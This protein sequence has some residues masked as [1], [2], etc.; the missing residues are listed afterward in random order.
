VEGTLFQFT[1]LLGV[2][3]LAAVLSIALRLPVVPLYIIAGVILRGFVQHDHTVEFLGSLG[4]V[5]L[6]FSMGLEFSVAR[7][8]ATP[9][10]ILRAGGLDWLLNFPI[11]LAAGRALGWSWEESLF[12]GGIVYMTSSAVV[13]KCIVD[14]GRAARPETETILG[15]L[16]FEDFVI[17]FYLVLLNALFPSAAAAGEPLHPALALARSL[18]FVLALAVVARRLQGPL[19]RM[20]AARTEEA[21]TLVLFTF[22]LLIASLAHAAGLSAEIGAFLGGLIL[23]GT[24]LKERAGATLL[25]FQTL[26]AALFFVSFGLGIDLGRVPELLGPAI[27]LILLGLAT[28]TLG[29]FLAGR[30]VGHSPQQSTVLGL[31]LI[32]KGEF[33]IVLASLAAASN[34]QSLIAPFAGIY[35]LALSILGPLAM[36]EADRVREV[37]FSR[38]RARRPPPG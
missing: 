20:L 2:L 18:V 19:E 28:K 30:A 34:P 10:R 7:R 11:G 12:L 16:V 31:S 29:G 37:L 3:G 22:V 35:V 33:S 6:L 25:P 5:F 32:P 36:R 21:F 26:F 27:F 1:L 14:F 23:G 13:S 15:I 38:R 17:A 4:V 8:S 24:S 9:A